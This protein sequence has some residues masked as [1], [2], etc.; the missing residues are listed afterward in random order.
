[1]NLN[2]LPIEPLWA[3]DTTQTETIFFIDEGENDPAA[4]LLFPADAVLAVT[5]ADERLTFEAG[6]DYAVDARAGRIVRPRG[7]SIPVTRREDLTAV[8]NG[9]D[10]GL[11]RR[12]T[13]V[14]YVHQPGLWRAYESRVP[15]GS[16]PRTTARLRNRESIAI[17]LTGDSISEGYNASGFMGM[18]P[19]QPPFGPLVAS[20]L[21]RG[22]QSPIAF[23]NF[24][25]AGW[26]ADN[27]IHDVERIAVPR[28]DRVIVAYGM[29]DAGYAE[30]EHY[31][32]NIETII[33]GVRGARPSAEFILV[34]PML[35]N[36]EWD[37][38]VPSRFPAYRNALARLCGSGT[39]LADLT[40]LWANILRRKSWFD[41][42]GNG[43]NHPN[44]FGHRLY[45]R[46]ILTTLTRP[47]S[48]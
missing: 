13:A 2:P 18:A 14:T 45:A 9:P 26:T 44:D 33:A 41:L 29:N 17:C 11:Q 7:S 12:Q 24:A 40:T 38:A 15:G 16:L 27:G 35:P 28:P 31:I 21:E 42:A 37:Y 30:P 47:G 39:A 43:F 3:S 48:F 20:A 22:G 4:L 6:R 1:V 10:D 23:H 34:S 32:A 19:R 25:V 36:P 8:M 5:S 46:V